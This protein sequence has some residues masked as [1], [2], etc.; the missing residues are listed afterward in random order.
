[1]TTIE[2]FCYSMQI[3]FLM[4][5][6]YKTC[7]WNCHLEEHTAAPARPCTT[8]PNHNLWTSEAVGNH[9][10]PSGVMLLYTSYCQSQKF[11]LASS[12]YIYYFLASW[13]NHRHP[14]WPYLRQ[15]QPP[16]PGQLREWG[17]PTSSWPLRCLSAAALFSSFLLLCLSLHFVGSHLRG[18]WWVRGRVCVWS[19]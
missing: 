17:R 5:K 15:G 18:L 8:T 12:S 19:S 2:I 6:H 3:S 10:F 11:P 1:M 7:T 9:C 14:S 13:K 16:W 4:Y